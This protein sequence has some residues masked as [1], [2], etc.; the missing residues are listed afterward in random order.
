M[1]ALKAIDM[2]EDDQG[3]VDLAGRHLPGDLLRG[4][5]AL[6]ER[7]RDGQA[8]LGDPGST[9]RIRSDW[10]DTGGEVLALGR[11]AAGSGRLP[12]RGDRP[13][14]EPVRRR[15]QRLPGVR[16][17]PELRDRVVPQPAPARS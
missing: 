4:R 10:I 9:E 3:D 2:K 12:G 7:C 13:A 14:D 16:L 11:A 15:A 17:P 5:G 8:M 1:N 6:A